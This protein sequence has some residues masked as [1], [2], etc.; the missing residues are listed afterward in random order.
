[1]RSLISATAALALT[2]VLSPVVSAADITGCEAASDFGV[3]WTTTLHGDVD[4]DHVID[5]V[6][7]KAVWLAV[8]RRM[9]CSLSRIAR[10]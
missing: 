2:I 3:P 4:G 7:T 6:R 9:R 10:D 1:M 5:T 8:I